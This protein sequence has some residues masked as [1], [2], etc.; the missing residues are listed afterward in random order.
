MVWRMTLARLVVV[1]TY[2]DPSD[3]VVAKS[4]LDAHG[5]VAVL[6]DWHVTSVAWHYMHA[7]NGIR[8]CTLDES[9]ADAVRLLDDV[10][11]AEDPDLIVTVTA[12]DVFVAFFAY[13][14][15][16]LPYRVRRRR[17]RKA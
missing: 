13:F 5:L 7:V 4:V 16:G 8:L 2:F 11:A 12:I 9:L 15:A 14:Y 17:Y 1:R 10:P 3:A 6:F